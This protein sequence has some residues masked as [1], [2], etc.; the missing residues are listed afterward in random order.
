MA[1]GD[2]IL[3]TPIIRALYQKHAGNCEID[4]SSNYPDVFKLNPYI[5]HSIRPAQILA[6]NYDQIYNLDLVYENFPKMHIVDAYKNHVFGS[7]VTLDDMSLDMFVDETD[8]QF[9]NNF[10]KDN[11]HTD[12]FMVVHIRRDG[13]PS[14]NIPEEL[15]GDVLEPILDECLDVTI[16]QI[17]G[18]HEISFDGDDRLINALGKFNIHQLKELINCADVFLGVD[19]APFHIAATTTTPI[20]AFFT[21]VNHEYR[22]PLAAHAVFEPLI[23]NVDCYGCMADV[24]PPNTEYSCRRGDVACV[25]SFNADIVLDKVKKFL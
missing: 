16:I 18:T 22:K 21:A 2:V 13:W 20:V 14:R 17:G 25:S 1:L 7:D 12:K 24:P 3:T 23:P 4:V 11:V 5:R 15:W 10:I 9:V 8:K 19:S 6:D